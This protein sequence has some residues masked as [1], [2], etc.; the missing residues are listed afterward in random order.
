MESKPGIVETALT[1]IVRTFTISVLIT[2]RVANQRTR[3]ALHSVHHFCVLPF[4]EI[5]FIGAHN[6]KSI[7]S[8]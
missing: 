2:K 4:L 6:D 5:A 7:Q 1:E 8:Q 3:R